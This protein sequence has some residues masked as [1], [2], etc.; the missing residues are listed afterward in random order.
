MQNENLYYRIG[1]IAQS[2]IIG[3]YYPMTFRC[4]SSNLQIPSAIK[5]RRLCD[6]KVGLLSDVVKI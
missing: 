3:H 6:N 1:I 5:L 2:W 4:F